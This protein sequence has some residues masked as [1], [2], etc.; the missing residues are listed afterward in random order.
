MVILVIINIVVN[1]E[2]ESFDKPVY[3]VSV[4]QMIA[5]INMLMMEVR[6]TPHEKITLNQL[7]DLLETIKTREEGE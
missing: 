1:R 3:K 6:L 2:E 7:K 4:D 5:V